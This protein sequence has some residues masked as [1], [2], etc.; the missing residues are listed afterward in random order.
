[1]VD[2]EAAA[3]LHVNLRALS[4]LLHALRSM[5]VYR[6]HAR[7][8][9]RASILSTHLHVFVWQDTV[10]RIAQLKLMNVLPALVKMEQHVPISSMLFRVHV[11]LDILAQ[12]VIS[13]LLA[14]LRKS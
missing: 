13:H 8:G 2:I 5:N 3:M 1:M 9:P 10:E 7:M 11:L 6:C 4:Q 12:R 14:M